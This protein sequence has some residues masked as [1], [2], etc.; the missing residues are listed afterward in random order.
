[1]PACCFPF[2]NPIGAMHCPMEHWIMD[3]KV[4]VGVTYP[5]L[6]ESGIKFLQSSGHQTLFAYPEADMLI[7]RAG[8]GAY[9]T[10][11]KWGRGWADPEI[12]RQR[13][14]QIRNG[15]RRKR[16]RRNNVDLSTARGRIS[17]KLAKRNR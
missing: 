3:P 12:R 11:S 13:L 2:M 9:S 14:Q 1:M 15:T 7:S 8:Q 16:P 6:T 5:E 17:T 4:R 10:F